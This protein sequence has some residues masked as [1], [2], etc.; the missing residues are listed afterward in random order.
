VSTTVLIVDDAPDIRLMLRAALRSKGDFELVGEAGTGGEA[1]RLSG[2]HRPD[3]II[4]DLGLPDLAGRDLLTRVRRASPTSRIV[5]FSGGDSDRTWFEQR[6]AGYV[7][8]GEELHRLLDTV[9]EVASDQTHDLAAVEL[10]SD[11]IA[12]RE[13]RAVVRDLLQR[14]GF[15]DL[16][17]EATLIVSELVANAVEHTGS[18]CAMVVNRT[19]GSIRIEVRDEAP[20]ARVLQ[21]HPGSAFA[22]RGRGLMI[23][24][25]LATE[26]GVDA[27]ER[28]KSVW[29]QLA[30]S[31]SPDDRPKYDEA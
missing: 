10:S 23:V 27:D 12:P 20:H 11:L 17:D 18:L 31:G 5:V 14:W 25:A 30:R 7:L 9:A 24:S 3:V 16:V 28:S 6:S 22:E 21:R 4:L 29:V 19:E 2:D 1:V 26:W 8:K 15:R 13:A